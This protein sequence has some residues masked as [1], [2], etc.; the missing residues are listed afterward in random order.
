VNR[1]WARAGFIVGG[2]DR[3][4]EQAQ[5]L[6]DA[7]LDGLIFNMPHLEDPQAIELAGQILSKLGQTAGVR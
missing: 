1:D 2:P 3:V 4:A 7:G 5:N 6:L